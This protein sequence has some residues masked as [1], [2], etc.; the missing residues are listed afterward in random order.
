[1]NHPKPPG[2]QVLDQSNKWSFRGSSQGL[3]DINDSGG[4]APPWVDHAAR[5]LTNSVEMKLNQSA[6]GENDE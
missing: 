2:F 4:N 3:G 6:K 1:M 5:A